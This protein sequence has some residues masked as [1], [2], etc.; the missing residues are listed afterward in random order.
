MSALLTASS[1]AFYYRQNPL[2]AEIDRCDAFATVAQLLADCEAR[3]AIDVLL[4]IGKLLLARP[5]LRRARPA[6]ERPVAFLRILMA[7]AV[8]V[9]DAGRRA[10]RLESLQLLYVTARLRNQTAADG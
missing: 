2:S 1:P 3:P 5:G 7:V 8:H 4:L 9:M 10:L 6:G